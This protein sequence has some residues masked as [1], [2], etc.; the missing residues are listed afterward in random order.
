MPRQSETPRKLK[1]SFLE[2]VWIQS[3]GSVSV[4]AICDRA[5]VKKGSF[6]HFFPSKIALALDALEEYWNSECR[7]K[8]DTAF[9]PSLL[10]LDRL[11]AWIANGLSHVQE[12]IDKHGKVLGCPFYNLGAETSTLEPELAAKVS[13]IFRRYQ[14]YLVNALRDAHENGDITLDDIDDTARDIFTHLEGA[15]TRARITNNPEPL[16]RLPLTIG[17]LIGADL[18][19]AVTQTV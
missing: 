16:Y 15:I 13:D 8:L 14:K 4:D 17:R 11:R 19:P 9:S 7:P 10:P 18:S 5:G 12:C 1:D 2:L 6:Y 3:Y